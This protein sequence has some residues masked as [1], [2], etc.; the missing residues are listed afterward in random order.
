MFTPRL[1]RFTPEINLFTPKLN[2]LYCTVTISHW[3]RSVLILNCRIGAIR[4]PRNCFTEP[5][6]NGTDT[7]EESGRSWRKTLLL[8]R[9][10]LSPGQTRHLCDFLLPWPP[11]YSCPVLPPVSLTIKLYP[12][13]VRVPTSPLLITLMASKDVADVCLPRAHTEP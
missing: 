7:H 12:I 8:S 3:T 10:V 4:P 13:R 5:H 6:T 2:N 11:S 1:Y 9:H